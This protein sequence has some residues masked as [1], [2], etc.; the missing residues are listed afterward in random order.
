MPGVSRLGR[1]ITSLAC[2]GCRNKVEVKEAMD[3]FLRK[4]AP[5][6][7][8]RVHDSLTTFNWGSRKQVGL[9]DPAA[10]NPPNRHMVRLLN[11]GNIQCPRCATVQWRT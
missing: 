7:S 3:M 4:H 6:A 1:G 11:G 9:Y 8:W 10:T 5:N 2:G